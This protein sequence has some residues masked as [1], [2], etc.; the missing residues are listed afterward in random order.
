MKKSIILAVLLLI[1]LAGLGVQNYFYNKEIEKL[2]MEH[3]TKI[4]ELN[5]ENE[6]LN[7]QLSDHIEQYYPTIVNP[8]MILYSAVHETDE[9]TIY[10]I[11]DPSITSGVNYYFFCEIYQFE[12][13]DEKCLSMS[14]WWLL[15]V[16]DKYYP[17]Y[18]GIA[19]GLYTADELKDFG[20][21]FRSKS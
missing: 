14:R 5:K 6:S 10:T 21:R 3:D 2:N 12:N 9:F 19:T 15:E 1:V 8:A 4:E 20:V 7:N 13:G 18:Y 11:S 16:D 17:L